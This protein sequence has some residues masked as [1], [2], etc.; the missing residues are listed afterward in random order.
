MESWYRSKICTFKEEI[1][2][3]KHWETS[4]TSVIA[5]GRFFSNWKNVSLPQFARRLECILKWFVLSEG[6][7][8]ILYISPVC[9]YVPP[10]VLASNREMGE[11][12]EVCRFF[13]VR[14][15][16]APSVYV[17][18]YFAVTTPFRNLSPALWYK[19]VPLCSICL[20]L[21]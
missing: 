7:F 2:K 4:P 16:D 14:L 10:F 12:G 9:K 18:P 13:F 5:C 21:H 6:H 3:V 20:M 1:S 15:L 17:P 19:D 11:T 8:S